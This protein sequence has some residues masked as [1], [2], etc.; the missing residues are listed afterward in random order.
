MSDEHQGPK[1]QA[2]KEFGKTCETPKDFPSHSEI[3]KM[4]QT[5]AAKIRSRVRNVNNTVIYRD[6]G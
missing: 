3:V 1:Q 5:E 4:V 6:N 2:P